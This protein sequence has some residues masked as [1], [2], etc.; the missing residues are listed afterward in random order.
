MTD[1]LTDKHGRY[2]I[3]LLVCLH[4]CQ[5]PNKQQNDTEEEE[6]C[7]QSSAVSSVIADIWLEMRGTR[8]ND[9]QCFWYF[10]L[11]EKFSNWCTI[12]NFREMWSRVLSFKI[13]FEYM[14]I[15]VSVIRKF[16]ANFLTHTSTTSVCDFILAADALL[17]Y[18]Q[19]YCPTLNRLHLKYTHLRTKS[20]P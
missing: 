16:T 13:Q 19:N 3:R 1:R 17:D 10:V 4:R 14:H 7:E 9:F 15:I 8:E 18:I 5:N 6:E 20:V 2:S 12:F 11:K